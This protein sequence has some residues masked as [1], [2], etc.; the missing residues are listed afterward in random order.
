MEE[1]SLSHSLTEFPLSLHRI[2]G[3]ETTTQTLA[4]TLW[5]LARHPLVQDRLREEILKVGSLEPTY[6]DFQTG[7]EYLDAVLKETYVLLFI[8]TRSQSF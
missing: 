7:F 5:E 4:F 1:P 6:D 3:H 2:S 8:Q